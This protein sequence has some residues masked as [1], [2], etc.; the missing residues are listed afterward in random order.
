MSENRFLTKRFRA[1]RIESCV[2]SGD[3]I[4]IGDDDADEAVVS[5]GE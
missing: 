3:D 1:S 4:R 2:I 5:A